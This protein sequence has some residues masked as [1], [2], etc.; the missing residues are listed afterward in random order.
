MSNGMKPSDNEIRVRFAP[1]PTGL[2]HIG[3]LRTSLYNYLFAKRHG[4]DFILRIEDTDR[5]R[6]V[7]GALENTIQFL[8]DFGLRYTEGPLL[9]RNTVNAE[10]KTS[11]KYP[12]IVEVGKV[13]PYIQSERLELY[14]GSIDQLIEQGAAY[15]CFCTEERLE[16]LREECVAG[17]KA[18]RYDR[19]CLSLSR[20]ESDLRWKRG[21]PFV[22]RFRVPDDRGEIRCADIVRGDVRFHAHDVDDYVLLKS[23]GFPTYHLASIV[24][25]HLMGITHVIRGEEWLS[26]LP[27]HV[28]LYEA[29]GWKAPVFAHLPNILGSDGR[30]KLSKRDGDVSIESFVARGYLREALIN[31]VALLGWN[32]GKGETQEI[33]TL[34]ELVEHF[35]LSGVNKAGAV[36]DI[37]KLD[38]MNAEYIKRLSVDELYERAKPFFR[39]EYEEDF[40]KRVLVVEQDRLTRLADV[41]TEN[42]FFFDEPTI[43]RAMLPWKKSTEEGAKSELARAA[44]VIS[45]IS[46]GD[47]T[48]ERLGEILLEAA[49]DDRGGFL[50]P[51]RVALSG[52]EKSPPPSDIAWV[53]GKDATIVRIQ[54]ALALLV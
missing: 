25:D 28:L 2:Q 10:A 8:N 48:R 27:K 42:P 41:G 19:H 29:F 1:S 20:E 15:R 14:V 33:F 23:D 21:D 50:W 52:A 51:L 54:T 44:G 18:P 32:P 30:K 9:A 34:D 17:K 16:K 31:F 11:E 24:D 53:I 5:K 7:E 40:M 3:G 38:W 37:K 43:E 13:G 4:G 45:D 49:G 22:V 39:K 47:W 12:D 35:D 46:D 6:F 26:S 36:F